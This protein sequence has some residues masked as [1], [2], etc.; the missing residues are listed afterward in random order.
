MQ[1]G[2]DVA[3][4]VVQAAPAAQEPPYAAGAAI[5]I[6]KIYSAGKQSNMLK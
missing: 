3:M 5:K 1:F 4:A 2:S 6:K